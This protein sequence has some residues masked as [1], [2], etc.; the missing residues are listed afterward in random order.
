MFTCPLWLAFIPGISLSEWLVILI[1]SFIVVGPRRMPQVARK[2]G[3]T[4]GKLQRAA[5]ALW[6]QI[7]NKITDDQ[8]NA[9]DKTGDKD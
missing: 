4:L 8:N 3:R 1:V 9:N 2:I 7:D 5:F 6:R